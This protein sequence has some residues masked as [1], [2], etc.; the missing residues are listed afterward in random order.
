M[1]DLNYGF[2]SVVCFPMNGGGSGEVVRDIPSGLPRRND[3]TDERVAIDSA[4]EVP[5]IRSRM[6]N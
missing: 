2:E 6:V 5:V 1:R 3:Y 4:I